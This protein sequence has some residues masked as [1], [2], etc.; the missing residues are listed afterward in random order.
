MPIIKCTLIVL[1]KYCYEICL[2]ISSDM[3]DSRDIKYV[4]ELN[5]D[6]VKDLEEVDNIVYVGHVTDE[7]RKQFQSLIK[8]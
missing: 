4:N 1:S 8:E 5:F 2:A 7:C 6:M 3:T